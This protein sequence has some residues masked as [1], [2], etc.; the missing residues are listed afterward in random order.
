MGRVFRLAAAILLLSAVA[1]VLGCGSAEDKST[2]SGRVTHRGRP[3]PNASLMFHPE[4]GHPIGTGT[5]AEGAYTAE[6]P[7]G[8]YRVTVNVG[9]EVP[10]G[11]KEGDPEP[12]PP[13]IVLPPVYT[14]RAKTELHI[15]VA[16]DGE[17]QTAD[18]GLK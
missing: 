1:M 13:K 7:P 4:Q 14:Q 6:V 9:I 18:F 17:P 12:P 15:S 8:E 16:T 11:W 2:L 3:L 5:D 10:P